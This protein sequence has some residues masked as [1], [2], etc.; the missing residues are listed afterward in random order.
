MDKKKLIIKQQP[1][2]VQ[3]V[4]SRSA[5]RRSSS[6]DMTPSAMVGRGILPFMQRNISLWLSTRHPVSLVAAVLDNAC[7][8]VYIHGILILFLCLGWRAVGGDRNTAECL[9]SQETEV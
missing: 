9:S 5:P 4:D 8:S 2:V 1:E 3:L 7:L 6:Q